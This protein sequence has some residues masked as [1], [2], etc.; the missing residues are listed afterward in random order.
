MFLIKLYKIK[1]TIEIIK[2][3]Q[4]IKYFAISNVESKNDLTKYLEILPKS[5]T[6]LIS[7]N[8]NEAKATIVV[9]IV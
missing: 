1:D 6:G 4:N 8:N 7:E 9:K 5:I 2:N 3:N